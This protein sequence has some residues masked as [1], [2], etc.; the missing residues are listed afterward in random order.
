MKRMHLVGPVLVLA[1]VLLAGCMRVQTL[2]VAPFSAILEAGE[3]VAFAATDQLGTPID[4]TW[5]VDV[6]PG[7]IS[8]AGVYTAPA[9]VAE[10]TTVTITATYA[11]VASITGS[12][13]VTLVPPG[14]A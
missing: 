10:V 12:A 9:T 8:I 1:V 11:G 3:T 13:V 6:G 2:V 4:V 14:T 5:S 7:T